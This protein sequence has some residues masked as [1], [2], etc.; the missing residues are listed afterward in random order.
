TGFSRCCSCPACTSTPTAGRARARRCSSPAHAG[1]SRW[2][3]S[4]ASPRADGLMADARRLLITGGAGFLGVNAADHMAQAGWDVT[5]L[6]NLSRQGTERNLDWLRAAH[7]SA[8][9]FVKEDV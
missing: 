6:D 8:T 3:T 5:I 7:P 4:A 9:T 1:S 2:R